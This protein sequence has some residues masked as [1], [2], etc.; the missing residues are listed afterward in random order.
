MK[1][2]TLL[3]ILFIFFASC[4]EGNDKSKSDYAE[5][6]QIEENLKWEKL[7]KIAKKYDA[8]AGFDT[9]SFPYSYEY[10]NLLSKNNKILLDDFSIDDIVRKDSVYI[11][12]I[13]KEYFFIEIKCSLNQ[14]QELLSDR[15]DENSWHHYFSNGEIIVAINS[16][17]K[18]R[19]QIETEVENSGS[20]DEEPEVNLDLG[21]SDDFLLKGELFAIIKN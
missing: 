5:K 4:N 7:S 8:I 16:I 6:R 10:Q 2:L 3:V 1:Y 14:I 17:K 19:F 13:Q 18:V 15:T 12:S 21:T 11:V 20:E 9:L